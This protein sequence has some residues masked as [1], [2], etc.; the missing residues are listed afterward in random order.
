MEKEL[1]FLVLGLVIGLLAGGIPAWLVARFKFAAESGKEKEKAHQL[2]KQL[3]E[4]RTDLSTER[5]ETSRL[6]EEIA[7]VKSAKEHIESRLNEQKDELETLQEKF[8]RE[9]ELLANRIFDEKSQK[10]TEQ[11]KTNLKDVLEPLGKRI[12]EFEKKV[13]DTNKENIDRHSTLREQIRYLHQLNQQMS[14]DANNLTKALKGDSKVQGGYG[15]MQLERILQLAGLQRDLH[16][17][18]EE[19]FKSEDGRNQRPDYTIFIPDNK[20]III[21]AKVSLTAYNNFFNAETE[22]DKRLFLKQHLTSVQ[23]HISQLASRD[24]QRLE[25]LNQPDYV[26]LFMANEPALTLALKEDTTLFEQALKRNIVLVSSSTLLATLRTISYI[27][28]QDDQNRNAAEIARQAGALYDSF[29]RFTEDLKKIGKNLEA[30]SKS[31]EDALAKLTSQRGNL[32]GRVQRLKQLG[33]KT[34]KQLPDDIIRRSQIELP[35][36]DDSAPVEQ[37]NG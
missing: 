21:D 32:I 30:S 6:R 29:V 25:Q 27:W 34:S 11:N 12:K 26:L 4:V 5:N 31:Y 37:D 7:T 36:E 10:F 1:L 28:K 19:N 13:E 33:A 9:F 35:P 22:E 15:E 3:V 17:K 16:Y 14:T 24:Y 2:D 18:K 20:H 8:T 23:N